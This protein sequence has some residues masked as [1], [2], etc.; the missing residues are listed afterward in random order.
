MA[1]RPRHV[2]GGLG[3][4][5]DTAGLQEKRTSIHEEEPLV[6]LRAPVPVGW[7][8]LASLVREVHHDGSTLKHWEVVVVMINC[9]PLRGSALHPGARPVNTKR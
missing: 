8:Q 2:P 3:P 6:H 9:I 5:V 1:G 7:V 4:G